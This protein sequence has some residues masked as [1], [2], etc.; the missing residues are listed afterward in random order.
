MN[1]CRHRVLYTLKATEKSHCVEVSSSCYTVAK[2]NRH[3]ANLSI[4][5]YNHYHES[6][7]VSDPYERYFVERIQTDYFDNLSHHSLPLGR[8][9]IGLGQHR[10]IQGNLRCRGLDFGAIHLGG[11][12]DIPSLC[13]HRERVAN[14]MSRT[15]SGCD[16]T[17][18][19]T[20][21][22]FISI[23]IQLL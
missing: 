16:D 20:T 15:S 7:F 19:A 18:S 3:H 23:N 12:G 2:T 22:D 21:P 5:N 17:R 9:K 6:I 14:P 13:P 8:R 11:R 4:L 1:I 10:G